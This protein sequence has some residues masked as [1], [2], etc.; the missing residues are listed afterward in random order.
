MIPWFALGFVAVAALNSGTTPPR[1]LA[2]GAISLD[3]FMLAMAMAALGGD[4]SCVGPA[5]R[6]NSSRSDSRRYC[7]PGCSWGTCDQHRHIGCRGLELEG[8][9][10]PD[11]GP[12]ARREDPRGP[13]GRLGRYRPRRGLGRKHGSSAVHRIDPATNREVATVLLP[14]KPCAG[15]AVGFGSLW[16]PLCGESPAVARVDLASNRVVSLIKVGRRPGGRRDHDQPG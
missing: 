4:H 7:S 8:R 16:V 15:L 1:P 5:H 13:H 9:L 12:F 10:R 6:G 11:R 14:G 2:A 3:T